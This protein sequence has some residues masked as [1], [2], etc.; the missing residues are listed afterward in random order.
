MQAL[1]LFRSTAE[2]GQVLTRN[3]QTATRPLVWVAIAGFIAAI[4]T[5]GALAAVSANAGAVTATIIDDVDA[6]PC[7]GD[8]LSDA[9]CDLTVQLSNTYS[10]G[11][12]WTLDTFG[13]GN[14][15]DASTITPGTRTLG[16]CPCEYW[17]PPMRNVPTRSS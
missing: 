12:L 16:D 17:V 15:L 10:R 11:T 14:A 5:L 4:G 6:T 13:L 9:S 7:A 1:I 3:R 8:I 2:E